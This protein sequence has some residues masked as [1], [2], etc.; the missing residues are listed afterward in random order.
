MSPELLGGDLQKLQAIVEERFE[1]PRRDTLYRGQSNPI[2]TT[3]NHFFII[4]V[5]CTATCV[6]CVRRL[7]IVYQE[8]RARDKRPF[9]PNLYIDE[10]N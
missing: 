2:V 5:S 9:G 1:L 6:D 4:H 7:Y 3:K 8:S 10:Y